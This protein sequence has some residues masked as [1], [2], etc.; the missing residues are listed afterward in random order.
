MVVLL[1][2]VDDD[3]DADGDDDAGDD[4]GDDDQIMINMM[5]NFNYFYSSFKLTLS[6]VKML[7]AFQQLTLSLVIK[8]LKPFEAS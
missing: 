4:D 3:D 6:Y 5:T 7:T 2:Q 8:M 1:L